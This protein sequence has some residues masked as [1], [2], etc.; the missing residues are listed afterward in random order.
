MSEFQNVMCKIRVAKF[1]SCLYYYMQK[2]VA[3]KYYKWMRATTPGLNNQE[4]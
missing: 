4:C 3:A 2:Y 1:I